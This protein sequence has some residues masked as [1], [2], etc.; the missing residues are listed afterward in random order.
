MHTY[1]SYN[2]NSIRK[3]WTGTVLEITFSKSFTMMLIIVI[4]KEILFKKTTHNIL[5]QYYLF[6]RL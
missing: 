4:S 3:Q 2:L 5:E 1:I 6:W